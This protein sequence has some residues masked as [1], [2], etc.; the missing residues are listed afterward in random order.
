LHFVIY[1]GE[2][3]EG[4]LV[5]YD[6][7]ILDRRTIQGDLN[8]DGVVDGSDLAD[9]AAS[10]GSINDLCD[11]QLLGTWI[12]NEQGSDSIYWAAAFSCDTIEFVGPDEFYRGAF[13]LDKNIDPFG[14]DYIITDSSNPANDGKTSLGI[15]EVINN[16][17]IITF[18]P[19]DNPS[20]PIT[21]DPDGT[22]RKF[23]LTK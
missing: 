13:V 17:L 15:Y 19:P 1:K 20:R 14:I 12:G 22:S 23:I 10:F 3:T 8:H 4:G 7:Q 21:F 6:L 16:Q 5:S 2:N 9:F 11:S 18:N